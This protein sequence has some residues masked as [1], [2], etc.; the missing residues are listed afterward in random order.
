[1]FEESVLIDRIFTETGYATA[2][3]NDA[4]ASTL[5][6]ATSVKVYVGH[7]GIRLQDP[8]MMYADGYSE[9]DNQEVLLSVIQIICPRTQFVTA[10][11]AVR[12]AY[13]NYSPVDD[14]DFSNLFFVEGRILGTTE[15]NVM[16]EEL[17]GLMFL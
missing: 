12:N 7:R 11:T 3:T 9:L 8:E 6:T 1:M 2:P 10:R 14:S 17:V 4:I 13:K 16:Y 15:Q 5:S